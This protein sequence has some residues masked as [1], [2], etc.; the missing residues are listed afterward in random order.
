MLEVFRFVQ[1]S[2]DICLRFVNSFDICV[3]IVIDCPDD[4]YKGYD[5]Q[6]SFADNM[7]VLIGTSHGFDF[8]VLSRSYSNVLR[9]I[10]CSTLTLDRL[11]LIIT[12]TR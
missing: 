3:T 12:I 9:V 4:S 1:R 10:H 5:L 2:D 11:L 7:N 6:S 8:W